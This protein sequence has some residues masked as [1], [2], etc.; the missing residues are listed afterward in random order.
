MIRSLI[1]K[2]VARIARIKHPY[3][4]V[5]VLTAGCLIWPAM[6]LASTTQYFG[7]N[8]VMNPSQTAWTGG[9]AVRINNYMYRPAGDRG[10]TAYQD[11]SGTQFGFDDTTGNPVHSGSSGGTSAYSGCF[12]YSNNYTYPTLCQTDY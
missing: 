2:C 1:D 5:T 9:L 3:L 7:P 4:L 12:N 8:W 6:A 11:S 10:I